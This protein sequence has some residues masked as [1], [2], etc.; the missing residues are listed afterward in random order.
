MLVPEEK[1]ENNP[2]RVIWGSSPDRG[3]HWFLSEWGYIREKVPD[4][5]IHI[6]Y[7]WTPMFMQALEMER[8]GGTFPGKVPDLEGI[9]Q[10]VEK[11]KNDPGVF[12]HGMV[13]QEELAE[14]FAKSGVWP[15][16]TRF[17]EVH[18][19]TAMKAQAHGC[20]PV[21]TDGFALSETVQYGTKFKPNWDDPKE[22][23]RFSTEVV[24]AML[25]PPSKEERMEMV[26]WARTHTWESRADA[27]EKQF[28]EDLSCNLEPKKVPR[29]GIS[30]FSKLCRELEEKAPLMV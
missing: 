6:Y 24:K 26:R 11:H 13:G 12:W 15:Y 18:C 14:S 29:G 7:G 16:L 8:A 28:E 17:P 10:G 1:L 27:W 3:L 2:H 4:A 19:I 25:H 23:R 21:S 5:E 22:L 20:W 30:A 9:Y